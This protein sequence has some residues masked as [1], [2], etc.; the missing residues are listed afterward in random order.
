M[1]LVKIFIFLFFYLENTVTSITGRYQF[2]FPCI[3]KFYFSIFSPWIRIRILNADPVPVGKINADSCGSESRALVFP[4]G[5]KKTKSLIKSPN[6]LKIPILHSPVS[7]VSRKCNNLCIHGRKDSVPRKA[8]PCATCP[9]SST[10]CTCSP[11]PGPATPSGRPGPPAIRSAS[12]GILL[13]RLAQ[14][15]CICLL[16][17]TIRTCQGNIKL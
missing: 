1:Q 13:T 12:S 4:V 14:Q 16:S 5:W 7:S 10:A 2:E 9:T 3:L 17:V 15:C 11:S 6:N 8:S